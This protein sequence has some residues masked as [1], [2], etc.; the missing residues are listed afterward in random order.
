M[1]GYNR[2]KIKNED[3]LK[4]NLKTQLEKFNKINLDDDEFNRILIH[5]R[6]WNCL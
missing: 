6:R 2:V 3:E 5:L 1:D 4:K